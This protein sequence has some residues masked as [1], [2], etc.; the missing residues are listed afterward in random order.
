MIL[1]IIVFILILG[2]LI[3]AHELGHFITAKR[4]GI[5]VEE[6]GFGFPPRVF[7]IK[8]G[9]TIYSLNLIPLGG[10]VK[11]Y[12]EEGEGKDDSRSFASRSIWQRFKILIAGVTFN[13]I[14]AALILSIGNFIGLP[15]AISSGESDNNFRDIKVQIAEVASNS[16]AEKADIKTGDAIENLKFRNE[17]IKINEIAEV[18]NFIDTHRGEEINIIIARGKETTEK[19]LI[20][21]EDPPEGEGAV[22][23]AMVKTGT[24]SYSWY[25]SIW[26]GIL[27]TI[28]MTIAFIIAIFGIIKNLIIGAP[29][30]GGLAGPVGIASITG[31]AVKLGFIYVIQLTAILSI[32]LAIINAFP[33][34]ALD[35]GRIL[36]LIIEKIKGS[37]VSQNFEKRVHTIGFILLITL[38]LFITF[39]DVVRI[40]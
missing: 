30:I 37:A 6:F 35:G 18:Q 8:R 16:P 21:R 15:A 5:K 17:K 23:I 38:M 26:R 33:F 27:N 34:P 12:G 31:Q 3:F 1:T 7:G 9:E 22:G 13:F 14:F 32:N 25:E 4:A 2:L 11:I 28:T 39:R 19:T 20:P 24:V 36:F 29:I 10:F 40:F